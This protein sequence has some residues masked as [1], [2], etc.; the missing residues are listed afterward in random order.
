MSI[1]E[2]KMKETEA[3]IFA[4]MEAGVMESDGVPCENPYPRY[5]WQEFHF[6]LG[7]KIGRAVSRGEWPRKGV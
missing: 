7:R 3:E 5:S 4:G 1:S 2:A 6:D